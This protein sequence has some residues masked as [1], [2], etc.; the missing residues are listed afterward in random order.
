MQRAKHA[1]LYLPA[2]F[3]GQK[4]KKY[5]PPSWVLKSEQILTGLAAKNALHTSRTLPLNEISQALAK[6]MNEEKAHEIAFHLCDWHQE[7]QF[8]VALQLFPTR[9]TPSEI[10]EAVTACLTHI[11]N[12]IAAAASLAGWEMKDIFNVGANIKPPDSS[13]V[14]Q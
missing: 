2:S 4:M 10:Q 8:L 9:F 13:P 1:E 11:P 7:A 14:G 12:H 3:L 5:D 6:D